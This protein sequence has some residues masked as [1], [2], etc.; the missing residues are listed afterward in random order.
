MIKLSKEKLNK[1]KNLNGLTN[2]QVAELTGLQVGTVDR[3]FSGANGNPTL[4]TLKALSELFK[5]SVD[6]FIDYGDNQIVEPY[7]L[8]KD[9]AEI[10]TTITSNSKIKTLYE[11]AKK[12]SPDDLNFVIDFAKRLTNK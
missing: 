8:D 1:F 6:D 9:S 2:K 12:L 5:C 10:A 4:E 11:I 3:V 7:L